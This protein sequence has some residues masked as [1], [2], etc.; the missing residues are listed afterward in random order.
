MPKRYKVVLHVSH[1]SYRVRLPTFSLGYLN[2]QNINT[3]NSNRRDGVTLD[4][5]RRDLSLHNRALI[6]AHYF[7]E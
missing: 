2:S 1:Q 5:F 7:I 6:S 4:A 3:E